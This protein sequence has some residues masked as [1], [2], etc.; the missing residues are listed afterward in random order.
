MTF[1]SGEKKAEYFSNNKS[2]LS[3]QMEFI[4]DE[5]IS[6]FY[7]HFGMSE[8]LEHIYTSPLFHL[9]VILESLSEANFVGLKM[10]EERHSSR[11]ISAV[12]FNHN[13]QSGAFVPAIIVRPC[14]RGQ[15]FDVSM[16]MLLQFLYYK[17]IKLNLWCYGSMLMTIQL[18]KFK[19]FIV[20]LVCILYP[21]NVSVFSICWGENYTWIWLVNC[22]R[23]R[24]QKA[25]MM[26]FLF[27]IWY[28]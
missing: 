3:N 18:Q 28:S 17:K 26:T 2:Q 10:S 27:I 16:L 4:L 22:S 12:L 24:K 13:S 14:L 15:K 21:P 9:F 25:T 20:D 1:V 11:A 5:S 8:D 23:A 7:S 6:L 19:D